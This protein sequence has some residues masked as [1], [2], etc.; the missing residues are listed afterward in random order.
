MEDPNLAATA[1]ESAPRAPEPAATAPESGEAP[2]A[3]PLPRGTSIGRFLVLGLLG[4]GGL[5]VVLSAYD[6]NLDRRVAL[7]LIRPDVWMGREQAARDHLV[8]EARAMAQRRANQEAAQAGRPLPYPSPWDVLDPTKLDPA[9]A[10]PEAYRESYRAFTKLC[11]P[12][13][14][15]RHIL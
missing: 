8:K 4:T 14:P 5:G 13:K 15:K 11:P 9:E 10:T 7:K 12:K 2:G 6:P 3:D 1:P